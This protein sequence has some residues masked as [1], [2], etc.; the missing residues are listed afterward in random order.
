MS[1]ERDITQ[2]QN[3][4]VSTAASF[5]SITM[6]HENILDSMD[7]GVIALDFEGRIITFN[8]AASRILGI[9]VIQALGKYY[10]EV[11]FGLPGNDEFNDVL[12]N[13]IYTRQTYMH[14]EVNFMRDESTAIPLGITSSLLRND[15]GQ[16]Y[17][18]VSVFSDLS[19]VKKRQFLQDTLT[20]YVNKDV[21]DLIL[22]HPENIILDGEERQATVLF[23][24]IRGFTSI[25]EK[26]QPKEL[27]QMLRDYF[28]SMV[29][30]VFAFQGT[31]DKFIGDCIM[32]IFGAPTPQP[33]HAGLAVFAALEMKR[34]L[35]VFNTTRGKNRHD[36]LRIGVGINTGEVVVG[37]IGSEQRLEYTAIGDAVNLA[38]RLEGIN[39][40]YGTEIIVSEST[41]CELGDVAILAREIDEV[42]VKGK[43]KPVKI[44]EIMA[45]QEDVVEE[46]H[47]LCGHFMQGLEY[48]RS[49]KWENAIREFQQALTV[50]PTDLPS[51]LYIDRCTVY[52]HQPPS[53]PW[54]G[55]FEMKTK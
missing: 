30:A 8:K 43:R 11:F 34:L 16:E 22:E 31:V 39:K 29:G 40:Q 50:V 28:T 41:Y 26:M 44:Y 53:D 23:S 24:D 17:G 19:E 45:R 6:L 1:E 54:D 42:R 27:V 33:N 49:Q 4:I 47:T 13:V 32:A 21:V 51:Q 52:Q 20:R 55:V 3:E 48:Y 2:L 15:R 25:S 5:S 36:P 14:R 38:S 10:P 12:I 9:G 37:N 7:N 46:Q 35:Q 18:V